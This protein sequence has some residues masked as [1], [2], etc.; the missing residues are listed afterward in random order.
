MPK[1]ISQLDTIPEDIARDLIGIADVVLG[2]RELDATS[3]MTVVYSLMKGIEKYPT[4]SGQEKK[5][6]VLICIRLFIERSD[7]DTQMKSML[8]DMAQ[9]ALPI[10]IDI[11]IDGA[12]NK[13]FQR[14][15]KKCFARCVC[16]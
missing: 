6:T 1:R 9:N 10:T 7:L 15:A 3:I 11:I 14:K 16:W 13:E 4:L 2:E 12:N 8:S 5:E